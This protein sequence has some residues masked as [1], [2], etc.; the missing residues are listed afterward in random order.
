MNVT[1][2]KLKCFAH[3]QILFQL[4]LDIKIKLNNFPY[5]LRGIKYTTKC[6]CLMTYIFILYLIQA[7]QDEVLFTV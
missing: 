3:Y 1:Y 5:V 2:K 7:T 4:Y 6:L